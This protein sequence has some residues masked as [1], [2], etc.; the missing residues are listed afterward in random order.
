[1]AV[2]VQ[3]LGHASFRIGDGT[4][5][6]ID[7]WKCKQGPKDGRVILISHA[8]YDHYSPKDIESVSAAGA[9]IFSTSDVILKLG[10]GKILRP[11]QSARPAGCLVTAVAAYNPAKQYHPKDNEWVGF[12]VEIDGKRIYYAGDTD[13][14]PELAAVKNIDLALVPVGGT[15][16][17]NPEEAADAVGRITPAGAIPYHWGTIVGDRRDAEQFSDHAGCSVTI[18]DPGQ[19]LTL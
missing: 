16:T 10:R 2:T 18:L 12:I 4:V 19:A 15:Y 7:P 17:M 1:M 5:I 11:G 6:Y 8:H 9:E 14:T 3:W 13:L